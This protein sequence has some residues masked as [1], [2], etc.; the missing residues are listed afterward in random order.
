MRHVIFPVFL[1]DAEEARL[2]AELTR[3]GLGL[4]LAASLAAELAGAFRVV[5]ASDG[6]PAV[7]AR[8][9]AL[10]A[11]YGAE[12]DADLRLQLL[13]LLLLHRYSHLPAQIACPGWQQ[14][15][16]F[17]ALAALIWPL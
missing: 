8:V 14:E 12:L 2:L 13:R 11:G 7:R 15:A 9:Q 3:L 1:A 17:E 5:V 10:M 16:D 6:D 4:G